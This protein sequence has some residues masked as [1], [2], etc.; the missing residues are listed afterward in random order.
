MFVENA[1][2]PIKG[3]SQVKHV[4]DVCVTVQ[5]SGFI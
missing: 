3:A 5:L 4:L 2:G 1:E